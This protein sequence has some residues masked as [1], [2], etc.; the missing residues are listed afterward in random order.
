VSQQAVRQEAR[1]EDY[2][3]CRLKPTA[4]TFG[5]VI[6]FLTRVKPFSEFRAGVLAGAVRQQLQRQ[7]HVCAMRGPTL[8]GYC[9]WMLFAEEMGE[10]WLREQTP[11]APVPD[12]RA[13]AGALT[14]VRADD[15]KVL[16]RL[17][18]A[19][20]ELNPGRR[21]FLRRE[22]SE[23]SRAVRQTTVLNTAH[24]RRDAR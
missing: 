24:T 10:R 13:N 1:A 8:I 18:R 3:V 9:G 16:R 6:D 12:D 21:V 14:I 22:Y 7:H 17:I 2:R 5:A 20:R 4:E 11:F 15:P 23:G 19:T